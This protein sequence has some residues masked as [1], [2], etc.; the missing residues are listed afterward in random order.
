MVDVVVFDIGGV[1]VPEGNRMEQLQ[2]FLVTHVGEFN[3]EEFKKAYW[4]LRD[5]Y[6]LGASDSLF[7]TPVL[8]AAGVTAND[9]VIELAAGKDAS[10]NSAIAREPLQLVKDLAA[11][12]VPL[13]ILS[14]A[15]RRMAEQ[16]R[17]SRW[18][19]Y[20]SHLLFSSDHGTK[21]PDLTI[22][23]DLQSQF[24]GMESPIFHFFDDRETNIA[25][26]KEAGWFG[27]L[28]TSVEQAR[29]EL[30]PLDA[31]IVNNP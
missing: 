17:Q 29:S 31:R 30:E 11:A 10:L 22:Y 25:G 12:G 26:A 8:S 7:W 21:K 4:A 14:N 23:S 15:P 24:S 28:W 1:L 19:S 2:D 5:E 9:A 13:G 3:R 16:V 27:Y 20:F 18:A 6:D